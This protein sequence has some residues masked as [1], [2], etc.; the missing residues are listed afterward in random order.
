M[1]DQ[2]VE[3]S[4]QTPSA[5]T[6]LELLSK[7]AA[8]GV[9]ITYA[10]GF[11]I[12]SLSHARYGITQTNPFR[13]RILSAGA[14][15]IVFV[16]PPIWIVMLSSG[17]QRLTASGFARLL[18]PL[19]IICTMLS[20][21]PAI[22]FTFSETPPHIK[23]WRVIALL[24]CWAVFRAPVKIA[25]NA[26]LHNGA[27]IIFTSFFFLSVA[28]DVIEERKLS[29]GAITI[30]LF[31]I[32]LMTMLELM[33][34]D[35]PRLEDPRWVKTFFAGLA[36][37]WSFASFLYPNIKASWGGGAPIPV[38]IYFT[39]DALFGP[40]AIV[41]A[42]L[43]DEADAGFYITGQNDKKAVFIPRGI[44]SLLYFSDNS[45]DS[46]LLK[47]IQ[48]VAIQ[49]SRPSETPIHPSLLSAPNSIPA[50]GPTSK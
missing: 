42:R 2:V 24:I 22:L 21:F 47:H 34:Q 33:N 14:W 5:V 27:S 20:L 46:E 30:W 44:V 12:T 48:P 39:K 9:V 35:P 17:K 41:K 6:K 16:L 19:W 40:G 36:V 4:Q 23:W 3:P 15:F 8:A 28:R 49:Q 38:T 10:L 25:Q 18:F 31:M 13:P 1:A 50:K 32:G 7:I 43:I 26:K 45:S 37:L 11:L 29:Y